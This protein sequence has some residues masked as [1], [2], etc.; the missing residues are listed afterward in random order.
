VNPPEN[1]TADVTPAATAELLARAAVTVIDVR[2]DEEWTTGHISGAIHIPLAALDPARIDASK[3]IIA[4]CRSGNRSGKA[5]DTLRAAGL[6][7]HNMTGGMNGW[8][9][10]GLPVHAADGTVGSVR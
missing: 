3:P 9:R 8:A 6:T 1:P 10:A 4:V 2:E 5:A 7:V